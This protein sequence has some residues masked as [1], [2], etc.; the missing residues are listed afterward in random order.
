MNWRSQWQL[1]VSRLFDMSTQ[2]ENTSSLQRL[3]Q[4]ALFSTDIC[5][6]PAMQ[7]DIERKVAAEYILTNIASSIRFFN[8]PFNL[9]ACQSQF[10]SYINKG[11]RNMAGIACNYCSLN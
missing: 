6:S 9:S 4:C 7:N 5:A 8:G 2:A 1:V 11:C 10:T 3:H